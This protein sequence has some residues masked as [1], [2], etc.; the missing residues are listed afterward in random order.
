M[1][2]LSGKRALITGGSGGIGAAIA[3]VLAGHGVDLVLAGRRRAGLDEVAA[4]CAG[5][6]R[7]TTIVNDLGAPGGAERLWT[8]ARGQG[9]IDILINNAGFGYFRP[10]ERV[11][12]ARD[13]E[14]LQLNILSLVE[15][16]RRFVA[17]RLP[18]AAPAYLVNIAS[19]AAYQAVPNMAVYA[20]SKAFVRNFTEALHDELRAT[21]VRVTCVCPG[22]TETN[23]HAAA[24]AGD[25]GW[26]ANASMMSADAVARIAVDAM[27]K[28]KR[29]VVPGLLNK[30]A[31]WSIRLVPRRIA[32]LSSSRVLG[33][34]KAAALPERSVP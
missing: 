7:V 14:L 3:R 5:R 11:E 30:L 1:A 27:R 26:L 34:P 24:G 23:F 32:S 31:A 16:S 8:E 9:P 21:P 33:A 29:N 4:A 12:W 19:L 17:D 25:Y 15:L 13:A 10:F 6:V 28:N 2:E 22:G 18:A 20:S